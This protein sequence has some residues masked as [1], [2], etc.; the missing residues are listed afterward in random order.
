MTQKHPINADAPTLV[1]KEEPSQPPAAPA[2]EGRSRKP[3]PGALKGI[4]ALIVV[5]VVILVVAL[6]A[7]GSGGG[8]SNGTSPAASGGS[9]TAG[10][11][12]RAGNNTTRISG[13]D[14]ASFA[15]N[16][17]LTVYP[18]TRPSQ[19]PASVT[20]VGEENWQTAVAGAVLM[21]HPIRA[22]L[23]ISSANGMPA[24][25]VAAVE[26]LKPHGN[27]LKKSGNRARNGVPFYVFGA[28]ATPT[29]GRTV[30]TGETF[31]ATQAAAI[32]TLRSSIFR[33]LPHHIVIASENNS[34]FAVP[35]AAWAAR[36]G[37]PVLFSR[38]DELPKP[39]ATVL[40][41]HPRIPIYVLGPTSVISGSV[42]HEISKIDKHVK[43]VSGR[44]PAE[45]AIALARYSDGGFGWNVND[46]GHGFV[47]ARSTSALE[48]ALAAPLS[49]SGTWGPLLLTESADKLPRAVREYFLGVKPGYTTN[50]T[51]AFYNHVWIVGDEEEIDVN[52]QAEIDQLAELEKV[53]GEG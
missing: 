8:G 38:R 47:V 52:Q 42:V 17:A 49:A 19:R 13:S 14:P 23:L 29:Q 30:K 2:G 11:T 20:L 5:A 21:A 43:R 45:N 9:A 48:A 1:P 39:T 10:G 44:T 46:P 50:P 3:I 40:K 36:S 24:A 51:R 41:R 6:V 37:D 32:A 35:A 12:A 18:S 15:A 34:A 28:I 53:G 31:G 33:E 7:G 26:V 27:K 22:P 16:V 4:A 25:S